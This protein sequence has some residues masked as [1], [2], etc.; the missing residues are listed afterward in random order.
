MLKEN[1]AGGSGEHNCF[2]IE[3]I[4]VHA[5]N[6]GKNL[7]LEEPF[8]DCKSLKFNSGCIKTRLGVFE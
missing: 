4:D 6:N 5:V 8:D 7:A 3:F 2:I 1:V